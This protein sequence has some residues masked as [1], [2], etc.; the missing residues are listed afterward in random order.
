MAWPCTRPWAIAWDRLNLACMPSRGSTMR[1]LA[2]DIAL[3]SPCIRA[4]AVQAKP[5]VARR[6]RAHSINACVQKD[7]ACGL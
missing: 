7:E 2:M 3:T 4:T 1:A 6:A 5:G